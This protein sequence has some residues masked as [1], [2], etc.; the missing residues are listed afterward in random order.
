MPGRDGFCP[1]I[2]MAKSARRHVVVPDT[3]I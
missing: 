1:T 2:L 3:I